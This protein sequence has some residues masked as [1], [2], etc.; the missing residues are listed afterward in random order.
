[1][2]DKRT[3]SLVLKEAVSNDYIIRLE[4]KEEAVNKSHYCEAYIENA[5]EHQVFGSISI[6]V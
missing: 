4:R 3:A 2:P 1:M 5:G 6:R